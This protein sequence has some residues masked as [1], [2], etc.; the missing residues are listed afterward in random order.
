MSTSPKKKLKT[1]QNSAQHNKK[2]VMRA[3]FELPASVAVTPSPTV[4]VYIK[5]IKYM[6]ALSFCAWISCIVYI[7][8]H[9]I[10][11]FSVPNC[12]VMFDLT[13]FCFFPPLVEANFVAFCTYCCIV[14]YIVAYI[15]AY[16]LSWFSLLFLEDTR[17]CVCACV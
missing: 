4:I 1:A 8:I 12:H 6:I 13:L 15:V 17:L 16:I 9:Q 11:S 14:V 10:L 3:A 7:K 5:F 2:R